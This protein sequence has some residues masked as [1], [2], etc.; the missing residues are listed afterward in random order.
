MLIINSNYLLLLESLDT[1]PLLM[2][3]ECP[4]S[5]GFGFGDAWFLKLKSE[6][7]SIG[8]ELN[9][10]YCIAGV[11]VGNKWGTFGLYKENEYEYLNWHFYISGKVCNV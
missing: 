6:V 7:G 8:T 4:F 3:A 1:D 9:L 5:L 11:F 2:F 10:T